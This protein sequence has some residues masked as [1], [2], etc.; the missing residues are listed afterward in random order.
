[1]ADPGGTFGISLPNHSRSLTLYPVFGA[2]CC[3]LSLSGGFERVRTGSKK[4]DMCAGDFLLLQTMTFP[5][6]S[7]L[8]FIF[9]SL[10]LSYFNILAEPSVTIFPVIASLVEA[11]LA[12]AEIPF[13]P[14]IA[15]LFI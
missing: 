3:G 8:F 2:V 9:R 4:S 5:H 1:M 15:A 6:H 11:R 10:R 14:S 12:P 7:A 13:H